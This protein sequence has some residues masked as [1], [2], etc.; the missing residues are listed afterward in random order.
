[1]KMR[2]HVR[3]FVRI[4]LLCA[5][6]GAMPLS[7]I[8]LCR[9]ESAKHQLKRVHKVQKKLAKYEPGTYLRLVFLDHSENVGTVGRLESTSFTFTDAN[10]NAARSYEY[11]DVAQVAKDETFVGEGSIHRH[12]SKLLIFGAAGAAAAAG[13]TAGLLAAR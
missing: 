10:N 1:M 5:T 13:A 7:Q 6:L 2:L 4:S 11:A 9:A 8:P 12:L 3:S